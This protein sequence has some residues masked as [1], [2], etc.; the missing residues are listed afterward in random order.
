[1]SML[2]VGYDARI[3]S[4]SSLTYA[5]SLGVVVC[6]MPVGCKATWERYHCCCHYRSVTG[7]TA[8]ASKSCLRKG[9]PRGGFGFVAAAR[10]GCVVHAVMPSVGH[11]RGALH[12]REHFF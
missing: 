11:S 4:S 2:L 6:A 5:A 8:I 7:T 1:M 9:G 12:R 10:R 3:R